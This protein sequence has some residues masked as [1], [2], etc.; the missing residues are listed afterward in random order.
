LLLMLLATVQHSVSHPMA[1]RL[2]PP[3]MRLCMLLRMLL[4][5]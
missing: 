1:C 2:M 5:T 4:L 3:L